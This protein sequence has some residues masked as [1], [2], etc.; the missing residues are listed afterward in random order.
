LALFI[1]LDPFKAVEESSML[2]IEELN[3]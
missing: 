1:D 2:H 3:E